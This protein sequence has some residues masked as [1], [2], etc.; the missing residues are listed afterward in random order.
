MPYVETN[1]IQTYYE[2]HGDGHPVVFI[3]GA[4][5]DHRQWA[6]QIEALADDYEV[7]CYDV[8]GHGKTGGSDRDRV[9]I[10]TLTDDLVAFLDAIS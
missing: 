9:S 8:R 5:W 6:P 2:R 3:H 7:I 10:E 1:G 4:A